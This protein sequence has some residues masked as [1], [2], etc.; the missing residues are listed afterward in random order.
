MST[1]ELYVV[2]GA[3]GRTGAAAAKALL[4]AGNRVRV[5]VRD[6][7]K[8]EAW[9]RL[10]AEVAVADLSDVVLYTSSLEEEF[11]SAAMTSRIS[12][13]CMIDALFA[14]CAYVDIDRSVRTLEMTYKTFKKFKR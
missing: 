12:Q 14:R 4:D 5:V 1:N 10:G 3:T 6:E 2:T 7:Q 8:G 11:R 9:A 13:M